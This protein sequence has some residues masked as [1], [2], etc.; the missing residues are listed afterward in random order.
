MSKANLILDLV[1]KAQPFHDIKRG[2]KK[3]EYR[4]F[5]WTNKLVDKIKGP[6]PYEFARI[7]LGYKRDRETFIAK[8]G[9]IRWGEPNPEW[10]YGITTEKY[11][12][13]IPIERVMDAIA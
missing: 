8:I 9:E 11:C 3:E 1:V 13:I 2:F 4:G 10:C 6:V 12:Y 7:S 5:N